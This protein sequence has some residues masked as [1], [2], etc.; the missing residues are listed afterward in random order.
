[1]FA[2]LTRLPVQTHIHPVEAARIVTGNIPP[3]FENVAIGKGWRTLNTM[4]SGGWI[5]TK[6][7]RLPAA[8]VRGKARGRAYLH[9]QGTASSW[10]RPV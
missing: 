3:H 10:R 1:V 9:V 2:A 6:N 7:L 8:T 5:G 4:P